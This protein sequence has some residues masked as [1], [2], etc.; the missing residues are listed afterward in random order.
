MLSPTRVM[1]P[2]SMAMRARRTPSM[3]ARRPSMITIG[4]IER[5]KPN[6]SEITSNKIRNPNIEIRNKSEY[7]N[8]KTQSGFSFLNFE[9]VSDFDIRISD[10]LFRYSDFG[11]I[12]TY[13]RRIPCAGDPV[14]PAARAPPLGT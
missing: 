2:F 6:K 4:D 1:R 9:F 3:S 5:S 10:F 8:Q 14:P 13:R 11:F 7:Q 12:V